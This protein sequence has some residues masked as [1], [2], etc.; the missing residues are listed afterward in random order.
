MADST[1]LRGMG[2]KPK[3]RLR[4]CEGVQIVELA[5]V[6]PL[7]MVLVVGIFDFG[8][9]FNLKQKITNAARAGARFG[10][11]SPTNDLV[12]FATPNSVIAI[13]NT[14]DDYLVAAKLND[15]DLAR[16]NAGTQTA[17]QLLWTFTANGN[18]C[19]GT[20]TVVIDRSC[21]I[22]PA[23]T[24]TVGPAT[25][26]VISTHVQ[27]SYPYKWT[28]EN[29]VGLVVPGSGSNYPGVSQIATDAYVPNLD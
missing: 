24:A 28:F 11:Y 17:P 5:V 18:G 15:C 2:C 14:V 8:N 27:I 9:A 20:L 22:A 6:L 23:L 3:S 25:M 19:P 1:P 10:S 21:C 12:G 4:G 13:K 26:Q 16:S 7:L 29:V